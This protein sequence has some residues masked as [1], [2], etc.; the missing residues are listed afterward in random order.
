M[1][2]SQRVAVTFAF[3]IATCECYGATI[4]KTNNTA[5]LNLGASWTNNA[6]PTSADIA[7]W[8]SVVTA[9]NSVSLGADLEWL[10]FKIVNPAGPVTLNAGNTLTLDG[11]GADL[12]VATQDLA[13]NCNLALGAS[14]SWLV[15]LGRNLTIGGGVSGT[16][17]LTVPGPGTV[18][19]NGTTYSLGTAVAGNNALA[20]NGGTL[21]MAGGTLTLAGNNNNNDGSH[22]QGG[23]TFQQTGGVVSSSFYTRLGSSG[24]G[25]LAVTGGQFN[26][27][28]E[29]LFAFA[30]SGAGTLNVTGTGTVN[31]HFLRLGNNGPGIA[32]LDGGLILANRI[33]SNSGQGYFYFNGG[34]LQVNNSPSNPWFEGTVT[35]VY[36]KN[37][38][39]V[40]NTAARNVSLTANL[41]AYPGSTNGLIKAGLGALTLAGTNS[42]AG[43]TTIATGTLTLN[44][45][46]NG[47]G[48]FTVNSGATLGGT[49]VI[50]SAVSVL[51]G[52]TLVAGSGPF[53][54]GNL[55]L[56]SN[57]TT[58]I[59]FGPAGGAGNGLIQV[60]G[61]LTLGGQLVVNDVGGMTS[62]TTYT[63]F[64]Y[65]GTLTNNGVTT[66]PASDWQVTFDTSTPHYVKVTTVR[67]YAF[68]EIAGGDQAAASLYTNLTAYIHGVSP[69]QAYW[70][71]VRSNALTGPLMDFGAHACSNPWTFTARHLRAGTNYILVYA[72][73]GTGS[74]QSNYVRYTLTLGPNTPVRPRPIP[75]EVWWGGL[76]TNS[77]M[78]NFSQ[79]PFVQQYEDGYFFHSAGWNVTSQG[80]LMQQLAANLRQFNVKY[81]PELGGNCPSPT[82]NWYQGQTNAWGGWA[83]GCQNNGIIWSEF[84]HDYHMENMEPV[85]QV[86]PTWP[87]NDQ[88][89]WWTGDLTVADGTYPY[90][91]GIWRDTFNGYYLM[92]PQIKVGHTSSPVWWGWDAYP[93]L[94]GNTLSFTVTNGSGQNIPFSFTAHAIVASFVNMASAINHPY[95][96]WQSDCPWDYF[97]FNGTLSTG[98][99]NR[100]KIRV[101]EQYL[102]SRGSRHTLICNVS[103]AGGKGGGDDAQDLY[104]MQSSLNSLFTHQRE[105]GRANRYLFESWYWGIP[106]AVVPETKSG[107]YCNLVLTGI[108]YLKGIADT[109]GTLEQLTLTP[110]ATNGTVVQLQLRNSGDYQCLPALAGLSGSISGVTTRYFATNGLERTATILTPEGFCYTNMLQPGG[111]TNLFA[112]TLAGSLSTSTNENARLEAF[113]NP[114]DPLGIV[115][116]REI[117][118]PQL[119]P[120]G[121]WNDM[122]IGS[123][124]LTGGSALS[125]SSFTV[126]GSGA[127]IWGTADACH[128]LYRTNAGDATLTARV[129]SQTAADA[130]SKAGVMIRESTAAGA[131][132]VFMCLTPNNGVNFQNR[133]TPSGSSYTVGTAGPA[134]PYWVRLVRSGTIFSAYASANGTAWTQ[135]GGSTNLSGL[136]ASAL[137]GLAVTA[138]T[139][140]L[141]SVATFDSV[142]LDQP[143]VNHPPVLST[144]AN[145]VIV[146]G[147]TLLV[148]NTATDPE[149]PPE[150]LTF[151]L[152]GAPTNAAINPI[153]GVLTWRPLISQAPVVTSLR[154]VVSDNGSPVMSATQSFW[155]TVNKPVQPGLGAPGFSNGLFRFS[156]WGDAGPDYTIL[157]STNL[158][159][160]QPVLTNSSAVP[161]FVFTDAG[162][163]NFTQ[164]FY[165]VMLG[166]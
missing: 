76:S 146:A 108:K 18:T 112:V 110:L 60:N 103:N 87:T 101:Y 135:I 37:G 165:R 156:I 51:D 133:P 85:C 77:Q 124:G 32:N 126:L 67:K 94:Y 160:W 44:G 143:V 129:T 137:W 46:H 88:T 128:F 22:I 118:A 24:A 145:Q 78:T 105:G 50:A 71:E 90:T 54:M 36:V 113:W 149:S 57:A 122:D 132:Q 31:S 139:N 4:V 23:A 153:T 91:T 14:Q 154:V 7:Q 68:I 29:I 117:F 42:Y 104:Y 102:Q 131:R 120:L 41:Q 161:P 43:P 144:N 125:G 138:H 39:A 21:V 163:I 5:N 65:T 152:P 58:I 10:G 59:G 106:H 92:F 66:S 63:A 95:F 27:A 109:N 26:N 40:I 115:R 119:S 25:T 33:F 147:A 127:D 53:T 73:D 30:G 56:G 114:Q 11:A 158:V 17:L 72:S 61:N 12:S 38:G 48:R 6:A 148:T 97:G 74:V 52:G 83:M 81:W 150:V 15:A 79:W 82:T 121:L 116:D 35:S 123:V 111:A 151:S 96:S 34:T 107:S 159:N 49:G 47:P 140:G 93:A 164:R 45:R 89:A 80:P 64:Y 157:G 13:L 2:F 136:G 134:A 16:A 69:V 162:T 75:A 155:V 84:T 142:S 98:A 62:N 100:Q 8:D 28:G 86:N 141:A 166:P 19:L 20:L 55:T 9:A 70:Y 1:N 130:W 99:Q 3:A